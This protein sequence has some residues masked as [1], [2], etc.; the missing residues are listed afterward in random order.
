M[1]QLLFQFVDV[2]DKLRYLIA[3]Q[4]SAKSLQLCDDNIFFSAVRNELEVITQVALLILA[5]HQGQSQIGHFLLHVSPTR[6]QRDF[7]SLQAIDV[8]L[9]ALH[10]RILASTEPLVDLSGQTVQLVLL[11]VQLVHLQ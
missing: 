11:M 6:F 7:S 10:F 3:F 4:V 8:L 2:P 5:V 1:L 9:C